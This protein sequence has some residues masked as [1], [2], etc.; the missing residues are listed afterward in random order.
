MTQSADKEPYEAVADDDAADMPRYKKLGG[1]G[2]VV[3]E[4]IV[5]EYGDVVAGLANRLL[6]YPGDVEDVVQ[7]VFLAA[8]KGLGKFRGQC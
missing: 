8:L 1:C 6:G 4:E 5:D 3:F 2:D 7:D